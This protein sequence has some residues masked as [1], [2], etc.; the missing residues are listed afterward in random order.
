MTLLWLGYLVYKL[1]NYAMTLPTE[2]SLSI[3]KLNLAQLIGW[4]QRVLQ[5]TRALVA[6]HTVNIL[7]FNVVVLSVVVDISID[8]ETTV[9]T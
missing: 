3:Q 8:N 4:S 9:V 6:P 5:P 2:T 1:G 7:E